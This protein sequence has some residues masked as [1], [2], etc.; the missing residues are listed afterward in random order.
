MRQNISSGAPWEPTVGY[1]RAVRSGP[2]VFVAGT[3]AVRPDGGVDSTDAYAQAKVVLRKIEAA[4]AQAGGRL[5]HVVRTRIF[6]T[7]IGDSEAVGRAHGEAFRDIRPASTM[8]EVS[9]LMTPDLKV[10]IEADAIV[11]QPETGP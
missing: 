6:L 7:G 4:L 5:D 1:S 2:F 11:P 3:T 10:E 9:A 8:V